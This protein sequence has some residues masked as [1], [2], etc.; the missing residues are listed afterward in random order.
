MSARGSN[1]RVRVWGYQN[2]QVPCVLDQGR[3]GSCVKTVF[4]SRIRKFSDGGN[5]S[6]TYGH[7]SGC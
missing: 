6:E 2:F 4:A 7:R 1:V 5:G 3:E